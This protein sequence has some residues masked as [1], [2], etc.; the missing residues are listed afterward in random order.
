M[1][2]WLK[3]KAE[4]LG[5]DLFGV[6]DC[7]QPEQWETYR[8]WLEAGHHGE[9]HYLEN[10]LPLK[11]DPR[12]LLPEAQSIVVVACN[13]Y[14]PELPQAAGKVARYARGDDYHGFMKAMLERLGEALAAEAPGTLWRAFVDSGPL[15]ERNLAQRAG[16]GWQGKNTCLIAPG[17]GSWFLLG[18]LLTSAELAPDRP[19]DRFQCG[20]CT[21]CLDACP[22]GALLEPGVLDA[23]RCLAYWN[24]EQRESMPETIRA[25]SGDWLFGCDI[26]QEVCPWNQRFATPAS[27]P[28]FYPR[29][30]I[31]SASV[32][33]L[34]ALSPHDF[35]LRIAPRSPVKR[36]KYRGFL[37]NVA[38]VAGN[39][40]NP[41]WIPALQAARIRHADDAMLCEHLDWALQRLQALAA[42]SA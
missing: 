33:E 4:T 1:K 3:V 22:T 41:D 36:P 20:S 9:M 17:K 31:E 24:I 39:S 8:L 26:C 19:F 42:S 11:A 6:T 2:S 34:L 23:R 13:Y 30:W 28:E 25:Q 5:F 14:A 29:S 40:G 37:R 21:R 35:E 7:R 12:T 16:L 18:C 10:H 27:R 32:G 38:V 15:L